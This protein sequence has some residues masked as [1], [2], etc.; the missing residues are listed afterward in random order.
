[1]HVFSAAEEDVQE[2]DWEEDGKCRLTRYQANT[3]IT[4]W[5]IFII[6]LPDTTTVLKKI[7]NLHSVLHNDKVKTELY[8]VSFWEVF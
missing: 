1:M 8:I 4:A 5:L 2:G 3:E 7:L 6:L